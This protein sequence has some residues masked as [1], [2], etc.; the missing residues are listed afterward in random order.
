MM[1]VFKGFVLTTL[2]LVLSGCSSINYNYKAK[3]DY[4]ST[5]E[6]G[7]IVEANV[8]DYMLDQ[9]E[10]VTMDYL[11]LENTIDGTLYDIHRGS[12]VRTGEYKGASY[13]SPITVDGVGLTYAAGFVDKPVA[14][15][16]NEENEVCV[17]SVSYQ[18]AACYDGQYKIEPRTIVD[19]QA[20]Q[21]TLIYNGSV[22]PKLNISYREFTNGSARNSFSNN[23]EYDMSKSKVINYK[24]AQIEVIEYDNSSI[25]FKVLKHFRDDRQVDLRKPN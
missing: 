19:S 13:F 6:I 1:K 10:S 25:K 18:E 8:G 2:A 9:G 20:F 11:V 4:F 17:T 5:P 23:V 3:V 22:G 12:Y 14:L 21:Q 16:I 24:G 7:K 15:H